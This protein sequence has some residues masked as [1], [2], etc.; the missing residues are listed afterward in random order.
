MPEI[1]REQNSGVGD[2]GRDQ[3]DSEMFNNISEIQMT[4]MSQSKYSS[5]YIQNTMTWNRPDNHP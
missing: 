5:L 1:Y 3:G 2:K 4:D